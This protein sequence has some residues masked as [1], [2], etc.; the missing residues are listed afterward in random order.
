MRGAGGARNAVLGQLRTLAERSF[1]ALTIAL[2]V[3]FLVLGKADIKLVGYL[4]RQT[5]DLAAPVLAALSGPVEALRARA[6]VLRALP[7]M[8]AEN[9]TLRDENGRL[10]AW[11]AEAVRLELENGALRR[12]LRMPA[13]ERAMLETTARVVADGGGTFVRSR[14]I[15]A[16]TDQGLVAGMAT[17][18]PGGLAGRVVEVGRRSARVV[19][20]TDFSSKIPVVVQR[21]GTRAIAEGDNGVLLT[22]RFAPSGADLRPG[23]RVLTSGDGGLLPAGLE[24]GQIVATAADRPAVRPFVDP[25]SLDHVGILRTAQVPEPTAPPDPHPRLAVR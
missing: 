19:L 5:D 14:L 16:G 22:L 13:T 18:A 25:D 7:V 3:A 24:V 11:R 21:S 15:D 10:L 8:A 6:A 23:D 9:S 20:L 1:T 2:A 12:L 4:V 17:V